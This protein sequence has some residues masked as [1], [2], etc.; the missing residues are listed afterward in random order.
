MER[1]MT[2]ITTESKRAL[3]PAE[4]RRLALRNPVLPDK[5]EVPSN[6]SLPVI[7]PPTFVVLDTPT[8]IYARP[9]SMLISSHIQARNNTAQISYTTQQ[10]LDADRVSVG[11]EFWFQN[12]SL[13]PVLLS[14]ITSRVVINGMWQMSAACSPLRPTANYTS[15]DALSFLKIIEFWKSTPRF[16]PPEDSQLAIVAH[17]DSFGGLCETDGDSYPGVNEREWVINKTFE[18]T[19]DSLEIPSKGAVLFD[20]NLYT[21]ITIEGGPNLAQV[22]ASVVCPSVQFE[23]RDAIQHGPPI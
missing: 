5:L 14:N 16:A 20:V 7:N 13:N 3:S 18:M 23:V 1:A 10:E 9:S 22:K 8:R 15:V 21:A 12:S 17:L 6:I 19:Y 11:F 2:N 4:I